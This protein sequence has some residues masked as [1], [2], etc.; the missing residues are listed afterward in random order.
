MKEIIALAILSSF[1]TAQSFANSQTEVPALT[2]NFPT[3]LDHIANH[4][5]P[6]EIF[7][8]CTKLIGEEKYG[9]AVL[10]CQIAMDFGAFDA[11]RVENFS[12]HKTIGHLRSEFNGK[13]TEKQQK[14]MQPAMSSLVNDHPELVLNT[15]K[16]IGKPQYEPIYMVYENSP[17]ANITIISNFDP[18]K[19]WKIILARYNQ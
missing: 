11:M 16:K 1:V 10:A 7:Q 15:L 6:V 3:S 17:S 4:H 8:L 19:A 12:S 9:E 5:T 18:D 14:E 2:H 13:L